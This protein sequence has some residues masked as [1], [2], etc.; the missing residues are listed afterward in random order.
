V[1]FQRKLYVEGALVARG[2][3]VLIQGN[4]SVELRYNPEWL[5]DLLERSFEEDHCQ[6]EE[7]SW[8][9]L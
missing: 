2:G 3:D 4:E 9:P 7:L 5:D 8:R 1:E 6:L